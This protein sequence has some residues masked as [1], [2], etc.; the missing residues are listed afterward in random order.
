MDKQHSEAPQSLV[1]SV[2]MAAAATV[3]IF[4]GTEPF[5]ACFQP[6]NFH[7]L[8]WELHVHNS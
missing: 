4:A 3:F 7:Q 2:T 6:H 1:R 8:V 5:T